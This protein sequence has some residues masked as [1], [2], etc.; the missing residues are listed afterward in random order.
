M[1]HRRPQDRLR[2]NG[3]ERYAIDVDDAGRG[4]AVDR[5]KS[6]FTL[7]RLQITADAVE[8]DR[9]RGG[10]LRVDD[11]ADRRGEQA[12]L[13]YTLADVPADVLVA[14]DHLA[15][16]HGGGEMRAAATGQN[17]PDRRGGR[18]N[19]DSGMNDAGAVAVRKHLIPGLAAGERAL[20]FSG[21]L[22]GKRGHG[23]T[24]H[25]DQDQN[26]RGSG[27]HA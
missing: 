2:K 1:A 6:G 15:A 22:P 11:V 5:L 10:I 27:N 17:R 24:S 9:K 16:L 13:G 14:L 21:R 3:I 25:G 19:V 26:L 20:S 7:F 18:G 8:A 23:Q 12:A 4:T